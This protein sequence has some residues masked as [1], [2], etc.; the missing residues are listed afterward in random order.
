MAERI[1][2][3][4]ASEL[5]GLSPLTIRCGINNGDFAFG[6]ALHI[7]KSRTNYHIVPEK[8]A[9]YLGIT[10]EKVKGD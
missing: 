5:T 2:V 1:S 3:K 8:L 9:D 6:T 10:V 4:R 7:S